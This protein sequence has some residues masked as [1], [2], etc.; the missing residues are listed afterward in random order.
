MELQTHENG[1]MEGSQKDANSQV[2]SPM[3][4]PPRG[5]ATPEEAVN[6]DGDQQPAK[7]RFTSHQ[8]ATIVGTF[9]AALTNMMA[10]SVITVFYPIEAKKR[11]ISQTVIGMVFSVFSLSYSIGSPLIGKMIPIVGARFAF[12]AGSFITGG[13]NILFGFIIDMPTNATFT[14][15]SF[16]IRILEGL[17]SAAALTSSSA[18]V[19]S[20]CPD[21]VGKAVSLVETTVGFSF[22]IGPAVGGLLY[23]VAGFRIPFFVLGGLVLSTVV[24]NYFLMPNQGKEAEESGS[25]RRVLSIPAVWVALFANFVG[26]AATASLEPTLAIFLDELNFSVMAISLLFVSLGL[27]YG[28]FAVIWGVIADAKKCTRILIVVGA[29]G[30]GGLFLLLGLPQILHLPVTGALP[31]VTIPI[32]AATFSMLAT[33]TFVDMLRSSEWYGIPSGLGLTAVISGLWNSSAALGSL[34][35]P[36]LGGVITEYYGFGYSIMTIACTSFAVLIIT[37]LFG[38]WEFRCGKGKREPREAFS[39][40]DNSNDQEMRLLSSK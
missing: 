29:S 13:C 9:F 30:S 28:L 24:V 40:E 10:Y 2:P 33:P 39:S 3:E 23:H 31:G 7:S 27:G 34:A 26:F 19:A 25:V 4:T 6:A 18:I 20:V 22:A 16:A 8:I 1:N 38:I 32:A 12:L 36:L 15:F 11:G 14:G 35:G 5:L 37:C 17:G 21:D